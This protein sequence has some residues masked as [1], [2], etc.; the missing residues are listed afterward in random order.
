[1]KFNFLIIT[2]LLF[3][4]FHAVAKD[5]DFGNATVLRVTSI[6]DDYVFRA[7]IQGFQ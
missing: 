4:S 1:M 3:V 5:M 7:N 6:Y 2:R